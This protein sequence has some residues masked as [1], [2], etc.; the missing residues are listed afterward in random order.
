MKRNFVHGIRS[1]R[2]LCKNTLTSTHA[3]GFA[4]LLRMFQVKCNRDCCHDYFQC[5]RNWLHSGVA[6]S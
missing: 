5:N 3:N 6:Y 1:Y 2:I 4:F